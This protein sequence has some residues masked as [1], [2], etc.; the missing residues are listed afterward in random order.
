MRAE[1]CYDCGE[2]CLE[3]TDKIICIKCD[4]AMH[5]QCS[6]RIIGDKEYCQCPNCHQVGTLGIPG[7]LSTGDQFA[8][9]AQARLEREQEKNAQ[10]ASAEDA[11]AEDATAFKQADTEDKEAL[12]REAED[13]DDDDDVADTDDAAIATADTI[14]TAAHDATTLVNRQTTQC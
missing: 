7:D 13:V 6:W 11:S 9:R 3:R 14:A 4:I 12:L 8:K 5:N 10:I 2:D 1:T